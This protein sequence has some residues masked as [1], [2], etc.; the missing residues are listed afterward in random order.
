MVRVVGDAAPGTA[1]LSC[2]AAGLWGEATPVNGPGCGYLVRAAPA[3]Q[4]TAEHTQARHHPR[5]RSTDL[6]LSERAASRTGDW[7][8]DHE[9]AMEGISTLPPEVSPWTSGALAHEIH[10]NSG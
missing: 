10:K 6:I 7:G 5:L 2:E 8:T 3:M 1:D 4:A 9:L